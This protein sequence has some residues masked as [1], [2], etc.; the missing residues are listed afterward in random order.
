MPSGALLAWFSGYCRA[1]VSPEGASS[2]SPATTPTSL[3]PDPATV[4]AQ[5]RDDLRQSAEYY[6]ARATSTAALG[7]VPIEGG[8]EIAQYYV[9]SL[10]SHADDVAALADSVA[11]IDPADPDALDR[12]TRA[13]ADSFELGFQLSGAL[14]L[15]TRQQAA[16]CG[17]QDG[18]GLRLT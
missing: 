17:V 12:L 16:G 18:R 11:A 7:P 8:A 15:P 10:Q 1:E 2:P 3:D 14:A 4:I 13:V 5:T 6:E 9:E